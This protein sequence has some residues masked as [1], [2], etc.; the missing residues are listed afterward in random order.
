MEG[1]EVMACVCG[2]S[3]EE[4]PDGKECEG[5]EGDE[6]C[7]CLMYEEDENE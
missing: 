2:H 5:V 3:E 6:A 1:R 7:L 4:H